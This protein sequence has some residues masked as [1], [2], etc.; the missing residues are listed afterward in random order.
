MGIPTRED[1]LLAR[2]EKTGDGCWL[3]TGYVNR[4]G[5]GVASLGRTRVARAHRL[6]YELFIGPIPDGLTIDH[7]C[8]GEDSLCPGGVCDHRKCVNPA[9]L[10]PVPSGVNT[11]RGRTVTALNAT[12]THCPAGH[13]Y[14]EANTRR[15]QKGRSCKACQSERVAASLPA[16]RKPCRGCGGPKGPG[17]WQW[18][19]QS[20]K[21]ARR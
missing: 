9:H 10:E 18:Y 8:H 4:E 14:T 19:C 5:Y 11:M 12:R 7:L 13:E 20:C 21:E 15:T 16:H 6:A 1:Y 3:W 2:V 17:K